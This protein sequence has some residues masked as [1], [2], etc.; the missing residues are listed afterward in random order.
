MDGIEEVVR[1]NGTG[2]SEYRKFGDIRRD[3]RGRIEAV[4]T[5]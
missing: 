2:V 5:L 3:W 4:P 1:R